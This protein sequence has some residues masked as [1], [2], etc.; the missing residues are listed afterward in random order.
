MSQLLLREYKNPQH[1]RSSSPDSKYVA[2]SPSNALSA[3][4]P[5]LSEL[6]LAVFPLTIEPKNRNT[7]LKIPS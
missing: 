2:G 1:L 6:L 3:S 4:F 5:E 7:D